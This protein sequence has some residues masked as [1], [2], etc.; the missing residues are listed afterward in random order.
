MSETKHMF[1]NTTLKKVLKKSSVI[2]LQF[3]LRQCHLLLCCFHQEV[4]LTLTKAVQHES[5]G[6]QNTKKHGRGAHMLLFNSTDARGTCVHIFPTMPLKWLPTVHHHKW[7]PCLHYF[8]WYL[9]HAHSSMLWYS[10]LHFSHNT[11]HPQLNFN[12]VNGIH[13]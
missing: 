5:L 3:H 12:A 6:R 11:S 2:Q 1:Y 8:P 10:C 7:Y 4:C 13:V 9:S